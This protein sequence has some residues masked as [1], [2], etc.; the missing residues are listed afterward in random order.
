MTVVMCAGAFHGNTFSDQPADYKLHT[1]Y[2]Y[3][4]IKYAEWPSSTKV[5][6]IGVVNNPEAEANLAEMAKVKSNSTLAIEVVNSK[7]EADLSKCHIVFVPS[8]ST[9]MAPKL[10]ET[11]NAQPILVVTEDADLTK[12]GA[13]VSF[14]V[15]DNKLRFQINE[16]AIKTSGLK[17]S[18]AITSLAER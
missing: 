8:N 13:C 17:L 2:I 16:D 1:L 5:I 4:F 7:S 14:K 11:F 3:N 15:V 6:K 10:I 12:K 9:Y 18:S